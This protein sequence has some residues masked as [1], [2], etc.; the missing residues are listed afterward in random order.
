VRVG[1]LTTSYPRDRDDWAGH[2]VRGFARWLH[3]SG[4]E[5]RVLCAAE[6]GRRRTEEEG[7]EVVRVPG[8]G[9]F[10]RGGAPE[11]LGRV[12]AWAA[13]GPFVAELGWHAAR[14][15]RG[16]DAVVSHWLLPCGVLGC[17][18]A[19]HRPHLAIAHSGDV[20]LLE[21][22]GEPA[23]RGAV[24]LLTASGARV[25][26]ASAPLRDR[27]LRPA[28]DGDR[29]RLIERSAVVSMGID[30]EAVR[31]R[32]AR[33]HVP[34]RLIVAFVG[35]RSPIKGLSVL[36]RAAAG[37]AGVELRIAE[38]HVVGEDKRALL[39][40]ADVLAVPS[41]DLPDGRTEGTPTV[42]LEGMAAGLAI[43]AS[44]TGGI[45]DVVRD[46]E[47]GCLVEPGDAAG[48]RTALLR[49][50]DDAGLRARLSERARAEAHR[51]DWSIVGPRLAALL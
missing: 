13:A 15:A 19:R 33:E 9:L 36:D 29:A 25:A 49:L 48:L 10:Y 40:Q 21:R 3:A 43:V 11:A 20:H 34:G 22:L 8:R 31:P 28:R 32:R 5:V 26:F 50:R 37:L 7:I 41:L 42:V 39:E 35:R 45:P 17:L 16:V 30:V 12:A 38:G 24:R 47:N 18:V 51:H 6:G 1:V 27:L 44:R 46:G 14:L 4:H 2:F 23:L